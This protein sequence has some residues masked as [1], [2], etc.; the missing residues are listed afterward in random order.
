MNRT[1]GQR[2][3]LWGVSLLLVLSL[4][5]CGRADKTKEEKT[6]DAGEVKSYTTAA[7]EQIEIPAKPQRVVYLGATLGDLLAMD[8]PIA[9]ANL[10]N[11][12]S[13]TEGLLESIADVGN[14]GDPEA[15]AALE[16]D[17]ILNGYTNDPDRNRAFAKIAPTVPFDSSRPYQERARELGEIFGKQD[18]AEGWISAFTA[19]SN[20]M[21]AKLDVAEGETATILL[22]LGKTLYVM[23]NRSLGV[24]LYQEQ[25]FDIPPA[26]QSNIIDEKLT[27]IVLPEELLPEYAGDRLFMLTLNSDESKD[28]VEKRVQTSLWNGLPAVREGKVYTA[29]AD[30]NT[31]TLLALDQL[32]NEIPKWMN[33]S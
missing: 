27:F 15:I 7:G 12:D 31:D 22:Q 28:E 20:E 19:K 16:P 26:V 5:A 6:L 1:Q 29:S 9:G 24:V 17:L 13:Q 2:I 4:A 33:K 25:G 10:V 14:P 18:E 3:A 21:W 11:A 30:W 8:I 23:G 32:L